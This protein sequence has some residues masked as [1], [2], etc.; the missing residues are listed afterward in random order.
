MSTAMGRISGR[1]VDLGVLPGVYQAR[2]S[3]QRLMPL[4]RHFRRISFEHN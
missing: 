3:R 2:V 1:F 4:A